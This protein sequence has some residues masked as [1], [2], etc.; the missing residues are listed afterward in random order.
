[1]ILIKIDIEILVC[2]EAVKIG[3]LSRADARPVAF[4]PDRRFPYRPLRAPPTS[5]G[6]PAPTPLPARKRVADPA[7]GELLCYARRAVHRRD[8]AGI[9]LHPTATVVL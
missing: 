9:T 8:E 6:R 2:Q 4:V 3:V 7:A 5:H 1:V